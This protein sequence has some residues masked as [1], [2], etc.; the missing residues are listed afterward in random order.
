MSAGANNNNNSNNNTVRIRRLFYIWVSKRWLVDI[1][2]GLFEMCDGGAGEWYEPWYI[3]VED[4]DRIAR[5]L[6]V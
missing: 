4:S 6:T 3:F 5:V 1:E 2:F